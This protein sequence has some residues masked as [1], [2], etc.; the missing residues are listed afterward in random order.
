MAVDFSRYLPPG[1][2][3]NPTQGPQLAVNSTLPTAVGLVGTTLGY[4]TYIESLVINPNTSITTPAVNATLKKT[5]IIRES[6]KVSNPNTGETYGTAVLDP[7][8]GLPTGTYIGD[9]DYTVVN[10][11]GTLD[12]P[13]GQYTISII[14]DGSHIEVGDVVQVSYRYTD[15]SYFT[16]Y[17]FY[18]FDDVKI[19]YGEPFDVSTGAIQSELT[20]AAKFAFLNGAYQVVCV[21]VNPA[22]PDAPTMAE[23]KAALDKLK[24]DPLIAVVVP[25]TGRQEFHASVQEHVMQQSENRFERRAILGLDGTTTTV[26]SS[27]RIIDAQV[28][29][30]RRI[31]L[32]SPDKFNYYSP[33]LS[34]TVVLGGQYMAASLAGITVSQSYAM[35][36]TRKR[37]TGWTGVGGDPIPD[38]QKNLESQNGLCVVELTRRRLMQVRHGVSTDPTDLISREWSITGQEDALIYR[39]RDYLENANLI[40]QP[41]Y[42]F[43]LVNTKASAEAALQSLIRDGLLVGYM[44]LKAR[45]LVTN[46]DVIEISFAWLPAFPLNY[47]VVTFNISLSSGNITSNAGASSAEVTGGSQ[48]STT[49]GAPSASSYNDFGGTSNT[50]MSL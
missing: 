34:N 18:D 45:Q 49:I 19:A 32:V 35:P 43:T 7:T 40:G 15:A 23:Y 10:V 44:G 6:I 36:L 25:C 2:Y 29:T 28:L 4:R 38:G 33:E 30:D 16:P 21:A 37:I 39:I 11:G 31:M 9:P 50:L 41:I 46:P 27:Q 17:T 1:V 14:V 3:T 20:L 42:P 47:I 12:G 48:V 22:N 8:T 13:D 26:P 5:G 24:D